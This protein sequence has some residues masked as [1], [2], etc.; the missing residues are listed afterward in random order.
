MVN[1]D[2]LST[3]LEANGMSSSDSANVAAAVKSFFE[4]KLGED[5]DT[6][7]EGEKIIFAKTA[8]N[9]MLTAG[10]QM[11]AGTE[12]GVVSFLSENQHLIF[13]NA[14]VNTAGDNT[15]IFDVNSVF[16]F[17]VQSFDNG[18]S[19]FNHF[20]FGP[21]GGDGYG[22][23]GP[24]GDFGPG[25][26]GD[27][28]PGPHG[29]FGPGPHGDFGPGPHGDFGPG[30]HGGYAEGPATFVDFFEGFKDGGFEHEG[31]QHDASM[32]PGMH[33]PDGPM[34]PGMHGPEGYM[35]AGNHGLD[36]PMGDNFF[37][38][39]E[40]YKAAGHAEGA[41]NPETL[42]NF[43][44]E[45]GL[46]EE[47]ATFDHIVGDGPHHG[48][49]FAD[50]GIVP[51]MGAHSDGQAL[52][53]EGQVHDANAD[54][55]EE[56]FVEAGEYRDGDVLVEDINVDII[57]NDGVAPSGS[58]AAPKAP[59]ANAQ[60]GGAQADVAG[61]GDAVDAKV[62]GDAID[63]KANTVKPDSEQPNGD[64]KPDQSQDKGDTAS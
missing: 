20:D 37:E 32:G 41:F 52:N 40:A 34:G 58:D 50:A 55:G 23:P 56:I 26:H 24:H 9:M 57:K 54:A 22:G 13:L 46:F 33:G 11:D 45:R 10:N 21:R 15:F 3:H 43:A 60:S 19:N 59:V 39:A 51:F 48:G 29:D 1:D 36:G 42:F 44:K 2:A 31:G 28:G 53:G 16:D 47:G 4:A 6:T 64:P 8:I 38:M 12:S 14:V 30:P 17:G 35:G 7:S 25:P 63:N 27:F 62:S 49:D 61:K 5:G 18:T